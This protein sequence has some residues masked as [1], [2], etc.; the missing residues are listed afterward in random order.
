MK[1]LS[2]F[3]AML[4][5]VSSAL[6]AQVGINTNNSTPDNSAMLDVQSTDK[7][8]LIPR[9]TLEQ[10]NAIS[11]PA[12]GLM[13]YQT[14][15][16]PGLYY[17]AGTPGLPSWQQVG[18]SAGGQ[19]QTNGNNIY[20]NSGRVGIGVSDPISTFD[21]RGLHTDDG[22]VFVLGNSD[23]SHMMILF[24]GRQND[25]NPFI[26]WKQGDPLR[27]TTD[28][29]G[30]S[31]KMRITSDGKLGIGTTNPDNSAILDVSSSTKGFLPP[32]MTTIQ[33]DA[34]TSPVA[35]LT[36]YNTSKNCNDTYN[37][38][39]WVSNTHYIGESYGGG[40]VFYVYDNGQHGLIA[41]IADQ[42]TGIRW[43]NGTFRLTGT[44]GDGLNAGAMN[45]AMIVATQIA[46]N[47][48][49][50]FAAKVCA[51]YSVTVGDVT[52]GDWYLPSKNELNLLYQH[53]NIVGGF[54]SDFYWSS[55]EIS[56]YGAKEQNFSNG[57][58]FSEM[59]DVTLHV[60]AIR[61]F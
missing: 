44:L 11:N 49:G 59:K 3:I 19:W 5:L 4:L 60:R 61:A 21:V 40:I 27:F 33:R 18:G 38:S 32:R 26:L 41:A 24:P 17:N 58:Q 55:N 46:D 22:G 47:Q 20:Y 37:G 8:L 54:A 1:N 12:T 51:E 36:I 30:L 6:F 25:P 23:L 50:N 28:E 15:N 29:G 34:I 56:D 9:M 52:F 42:S 31:E 45:T 35:G 53:K 2:C 13:I 43:Y 10:R 14:D 16:T 57:D 48:F 7:G 39:F